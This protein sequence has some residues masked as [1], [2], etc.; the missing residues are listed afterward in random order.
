MRAALLVV[1]LWSFVAGEGP[2]AVRTAEAERLL[3]LSEQVIAGLP[4]SSPA[5]HEVRAFRSKIATLLDAAQTEWKAELGDCLRIEEPEADA[6]EEQLLRVHTEAHM[7][8]LD[9]A[10]ARAKRWPTPI[11]IDADTAV[12]AKSE[13][14]AKRA[15]GLVI[16]AV[17]SVFGDADAPQRAFVMARPPGHHATPNRPMGFCCYNNVLVGVAHAQAVHG[18]KRVAILDFDVHHGNGSQE[19]IQGDPEIL[20]VS[21]HRHE[22]G[23]FYPGTG[24]AADTGSVGNCVNVAWPTGGVKDGDYMAAWHRLIYP[25]ATE[26]RP[27][28]AII[29]AG[30][31]AAV[32]DPLGGCQVT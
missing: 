7:E 25:I 18:L 20:F 22:G 6:T 1:G 26:F 28:L 4:A 30:F 3:R 12:S 11:P 17:D 16:A 9:S 24:A 29:S 13:A 19:M 31:D 32:G 8:A 2:G 21:L 14:A 5:K 10:F 23:R 15:A 27:H